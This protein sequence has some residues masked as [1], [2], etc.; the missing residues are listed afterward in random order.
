MSL[1][2]AAECSIN[3]FLLIGMVEQ[4]ILEQLGYQA[5]EATLDE[6]AKV[7]FLGQL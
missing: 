4:S 5:L 2:N 3:I 7:L 6:K 1:P